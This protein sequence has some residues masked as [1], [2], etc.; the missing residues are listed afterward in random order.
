MVLYLA[1]YP[2]S[3]PIPSRPSSYRIN[4]KGKKE[5]ADKEKRYRKKSKQVTFNGFAWSSPLSIPCDKK[6]KQA[7][8]KKSQ[9]D[10]PRRCQHALCIARKKQH[11]SIS[12]FTL[13]HQGGCCCWVS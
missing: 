2:L 5:Q 4:R 10:T 11:H 7:S 8:Y 6:K 13:G 1:I 12:G 9:T 3:H